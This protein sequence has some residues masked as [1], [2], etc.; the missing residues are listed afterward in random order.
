MADTATL[1]EIR[2]EAPTPGR[3]APAEHQP[4]W[5]SGYGTRLLLTDAV[6]VYIAVFTAYVVRFDDLGA[7]R[8]RGEMEP[9][10]LIV[11]I[12]LMW[13]WLL[14]LVVGRTQDRRIVGAG[15]AEYQRVVGATWRIFAAV[16]V[17]SFLL[18]MEIARGYLAIA[19]P[20]G[21]VLVLAGRLL[22]RR[23]LHRERRAGHLLSRVV[24]IGHRSKAEALVRELAGRPLAGFGVVGVCVS[25]GPVPLGETVL[26]VPVLGTFVDAAQVARDVRADAV[27][28]S[29]SDAITADAVR[30]LGWDLEGSGIDL[31]LAVSLTDVAGPRVLMQP[32]SGLPMMYV[33]EPRFSGPKYALKSAFDVVCAVV[34]L[35][36][37][38]PLLAVV[39][40]AVKATSRGPVFFFQERVGRN[41][42][43][44][45]VVKFRSMQA[46]AH[47][48]LDE[49]MGDDLPL[50]YKLQVD[51]RVTPLGKVLR[52]YS[53]DELPQL[54][55]VLRG[56][57]SLVGPRPQIDREVAQ[58]DRA[59]HRRLLVKPGLTGLW[60]VSGR[61]GLSPEEGI[62][63][64]VYYVENW[65]LFGD[66]AIL[67]RTAKAVVQGEGAY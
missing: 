11:S 29:G 50:F 32:V 17:M 20:L 48:M 62:R 43:S 61:S 30:K 40:A 41:G 2:Q 7:A 1:D 60:Q 23:W 15:P 27:A 56:E 4:R 45:R 42:R 31:A 46:G 10:Y 44:F 16:A 59:A 57:M 5:W 47:A 67:F 9:S 37:L 6:A 3:T 65:T 52:R 38:S 66:L 36:L 24:V 22:S 26:G 49:V 55:N 58:Y 28:V 19:F 8:V 63:M 54:F 51:P 33:D 39:A 12:A 18:R 34:I 53:L 13:A 25:D 35:V 64:D 14:A 21:T